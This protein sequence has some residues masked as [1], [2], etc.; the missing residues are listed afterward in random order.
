M[1]L[2][3]FLRKPFDMNLE[4]LLPELIELF[5]SNCETFVLVYTIS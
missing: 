5:Q 3:L 1:S 2:F 4:V